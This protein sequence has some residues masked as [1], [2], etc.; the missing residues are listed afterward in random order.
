[1]KAQKLKKVFLLI[2][3]P[4]SLLQGSCLSQNANTTTTTPDTLAQSGELTNTIFSNLANNVIVPTYLNWLDASESLTT[5]MDQLCAAPTS[6]A[7]ENAQEAWRNSHALYEQTQA[8]DFGPST[9]LQ[10]QNKVNF[11]PPSTT[12]IETII[13]GDGTIDL[14]FINARPVA[15]KGFFGLE[16]LLFDPVGGNANILTQLTDPTDGARRCQYARL[17][18][19]NLQAQAAE[20]YN[21]W[22]EEDGNFIDEFALAGQGS[23][24]YSMV[25]NAMGA[26]VNA[27]IANA[28]HIQDAKLGKPLGKRTGGTAQPEE[29]ESFYS[30]NSLNDMVN[31]IKG[32]QNIYLGSYENN[33]GLS[34]S[35]YVLQTD[36]SLDKR[37]K[38]RIASC[39]AAIRLIPG[40]LDVAVVTHPNA[41]ENAYEEV[42]QLRIIFEGQMSSVL[43]SSIVFNSNDGD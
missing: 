33:S 18:S 39:L 8:F 11:S 41:V 37:I 12:A 19:V 43:G 36:S 5:S 23:S 29:V 1:M 26:L 9:S 20:L 31:N 7:L 42:R 21:A 14:V 24:T 6:T 2:L 28:E 27:M 34:L 13:A 40:D 25:S 30:D 22:S 16:Y 35:T 17:V 4:F 38:D 32:I 15:L 10:I 3:F